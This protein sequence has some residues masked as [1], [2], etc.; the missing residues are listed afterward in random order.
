VLIINVLFNGNTSMAQIGHCKR[1]EDM[2]VELVLPGTEGDI[3]YHPIDYGLVDKLKKVPGGAK[4][5][6]GCRHCGQN[7]PPKYGRLHGLI[8]H[9]DAKYGTLLIP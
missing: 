4:G 8:S 5:K 9:L 3:L 2:E 6:F 1:H 7:S